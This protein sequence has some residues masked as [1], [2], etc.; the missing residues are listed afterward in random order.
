MCSP[1]HVAITNL[2][3]RYAEL[4][5]AG[6]LDGVAELFAH[7]GIAAGG[8]LLEGRDAV[9]AMYAGV[10]LYD[11]GTPAT[12][13]VTTNLIVDVD[14]DSG[15][16]TCRSYVTVFQYLPDFPLQAVYQCR[17]LDSFDRVEG[18]WRFKVREMVDHRPGDTSR[19]LQQ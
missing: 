14:E 2:V 12:K 16:G 7:G 1:G 17:Y 19:H 3:H 10:I 13:H 18:E 5:D 8:A 4:I 9:K 11:D 15:I 6:D